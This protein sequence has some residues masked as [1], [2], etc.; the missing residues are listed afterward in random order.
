MSLPA[1]IRINAIVSFPSRAVGSGPITVRK[2]NGVFTVGYDVSGYPLLNPPFDPTTK[3][4]FVWDPVTNLF[5]NLSVA[6]LF[7]SVLSGSVIK[8]TAAGTV[9]V[10][11]STTAVLIAKSVA[12]PTPIVLPSIAVREGLALHISDVNGN[13]GDITI[14]PDGSEKIMGQSSWIS[15]DGAGNGGNLDLTPSTDINGWFF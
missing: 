1:N 15:G 11:P 13:G 2:A 7:S 4:V 6:A 5:Y 9:T 3:R 8:V 10:G 14:T 12:S